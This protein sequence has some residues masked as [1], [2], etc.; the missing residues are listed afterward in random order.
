MKWVKLHVRLFRL[1]LLHTRGQDTNRTHTH[2]NTH[3]FMCTDLV[4]KY[5]T[6]KKPACNN[7]QSELALAL[8]ICKIHVKISENILLSIFYHS[9]FRRFF[10]SF[11]KSK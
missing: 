9:H 3:P 4:D 10:Y 5:E 11:F 1:T 8:T 2:I 6:E 7:K